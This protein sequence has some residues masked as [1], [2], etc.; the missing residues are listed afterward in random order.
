VTC[1][2][3]AWTTVNVSFQQSKGTGFATEFV[4][5]S[6]SPGTPATWTAFA[7]Y[8]G[9]FRLGASQGSAF[10]YAE[11]ANDGT[12]ADSPSVNETVVLVPGHG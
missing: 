11:D 5:V 1:T 2:Q 8:N 3:Y 7:G 6:C 10:A 4:T 9:T 12:I